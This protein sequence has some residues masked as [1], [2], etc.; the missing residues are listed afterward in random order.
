MTQPL[1]PPVPQTTPTPPPM[2]RPPMPGPPMSAYGPPPS[3]GGPPP[4]P[5]FALAWWGGLAVL[6][7]VPL[8]IWKSWSDAPSE[9]PYPN[10]PLSYVV[11]YVVGG[12]AFP[13]LAAY[14]V[15]RFV[16][17]SRTVTT[18]VFCAGVFLAIASVANP[19]QSRRQTQRVIDGVV[20]N[21][22]QK[23]AAAE[24]AVAEVRAA[25][26]LQPHGLES[27]DGFEKRLAILEEATRTNRELIAAGDAAEAE[28]AAGLE[29]AG[30][31]EGRREE[32]VAQFRTKY[33]WAAGRSVHESNARILAAS[34]K[35]LEFLQRHRGR[36][37]YNEQA[38]L[39]E[40]DDDALIE[41][42]SQLQSELAKAVEAQRTMPTG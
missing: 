36:W 18:I 13:L 17:T 11:G 10:V 20:Q 39:V 1:P 12:V 27:A 42:F 37:R 24:A 30:V 7:W 3:V 28:L 38:N 23:R 19:G 32:I 35:I 26:V 8:A 25:Q 6:V 33:N 2:P 29:Q 15:W 14:L 9:A 16:R 34:G 41:E 31:R 21:L 40:F 5:K 22:E 4:R